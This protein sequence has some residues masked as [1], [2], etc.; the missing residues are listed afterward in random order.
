LAADTPGI[1]GA[2]LSGAGPSVLIFLDDKVGA[3]SAQAKVRSS[4]KASGLKAD[5]VPTAITNQGA[6]QG[7]AWTQ[8]R[9]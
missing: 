2:V 9:V 4:L 7:K 6:G 3:E 5:L 1:L 8:R